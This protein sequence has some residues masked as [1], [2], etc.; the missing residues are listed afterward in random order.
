MYIKMFH[1]N[2]EKSMIQGLDSLF[3]EWRL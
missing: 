3:W 1:D 2:N